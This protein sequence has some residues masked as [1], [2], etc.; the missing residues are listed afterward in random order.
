MGIGRIRGRPRLQA[1]L[2]LV[3][4]CA[5][6]LAGWWLLGESELP[7]RFVVVEPGR[8]YRSGQPKAAQL[9]RV[10]DRHGIR[11]ILVLRPPPYPEFADEKRLAAER[12]VE[13]RSLPISRPG[14]MTPAQRH[15]IR[16]V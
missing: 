11:T 4:A 10:L 1:A 13:L 9:E 16:R 5:A 2:V 14:P 3:P 6:G 15:A 7:R 12:R 8:L